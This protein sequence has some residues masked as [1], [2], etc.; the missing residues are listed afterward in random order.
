MAIT[1]EQIR[2][3][4]TQYESRG[5][6]KAAADLNAVS[7]AQGNVAR[8]GATMATVTD[9]V[10]KRQLDAGR[11]ADT[12]RRKY[13][14]E[15]R[16]LQTLAREHQRLDRAKQTGRLTAEDYSRT[17]D[18]MHAKLGVVSQAQAEATR[19]V[20]QETRAIEEA[21]AAQQRYA[22]LLGVR[23][24]F[25][26][27]ARAADIAAFA[28]EYDRYI[29]KLVAAKN[30]EQDLARTRAAS[31]QTSINERLGVRD[32]FGTEA[33]AAD[34][35]A[36]AR[37]YEHYVATLVAARK[38][39]DDLA[40][41]R[42]ANAQT[43]I[44]QRLGVRDDFGSTAR[45][46]DIAAVGDEIQRLREKYV[47]LTA[48][49]RQYRQ[50]LEEINQA[51]KVGILTEVQ[52]A[53][54]VART[55]TV[56]AEQVVAM[57]GVQEATGR[58]RLAG[59]DL[60]NLSYQLNDVFTMMAM[61]A[62]PMQIVASQLGQIYQILAGQQGGV[63]GG[64]KALGGSIA[65]LVTPAG[66]AVTAV[67]AIGV[68]AVASYGS[69][70][71]GE[72]QLQAALQGRGRA[73]AA[74]VDELNEIAL[75]AA[76]ATDATVGEAR[77]I[78]AALTSTGKVGV[79]FYEGL[80]GATK[81]YAAVT[82]QELSAASAEIAAAFADPAKGAEDLN[83]KLL[84]LDGTTLRYIRDLATS[85]RTHE[86]AAVL[87]QRLT[88][89]L[90]PAAENLTLLGRA[91][92]S[93]RNMASDAYAAMGRGVDAL[94]SGPSLD[95]RIATAE[96]QLRDLEGVQ[97]RSGQYGYSYDEVLKRQRELNTELSKLYADR[98]LIEAQGVRTARN[99]LDQEAR[100][101]LGSRDPRIEQVLTLQKEQAK[102]REALAAGVGDG[103]AQEAALQGITNQI[104][105]MTDAYGNLIPQA[106][107]V[108][109]EQELQ[110]AL[111]TATTPAQR[112]AAS[113][114]LE[115]FRAEAEG[116]D[117]ATASAKAKRSAPAW[118]PQ[119]EYAGD[120]PLDRRTVRRRR[121]DGRFAH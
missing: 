109:R 94:L 18:L 79:D 57:R 73:T 33:R 103:A 61:G 37:E 80:V 25:G 27:E 89:T 43:S 44:N 115:R 4:V 2:R 58:V 71:A 75:A 74:T 64:L 55:K 14:E 63:V 77:E 22:T 96:G 108:R 12:I 19:R 84:F 32:D 45:A 90:P 31:A 105:S 3:V 40:R 23:D 53:D 50:T 101:I 117:N 39:E 7:S 113:A 13:D 51:A 82:Q 111:A 35:A 91:W 5:A 76:D 118:R 102:L 107:A 46:A 15:F 72:K 88:Q 121:R 86:A 17:L 116:A 11:A 99:V 29:A 119:S 21:A 66:A 9:T 98:A 68:A 1:V 48:L 65:G 78:V 112:A 100:A 36:F 26:T 97:A 110:N 54:A 24:D 62:P 93:V 52:R 34:I 69:W 92:L 59:H 95:E 70:L 30:A 67:A 81:Q 8:T 104:R 41:S 83:K 60:A 114:A 47:P 6:D 38:A 28:Q 16:T 10:T 120:F 49:Q 42:A 87:L 85:N 106:E 20:Q 56:F